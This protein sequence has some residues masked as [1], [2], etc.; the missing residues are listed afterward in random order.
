MYVLTYVTLHT[1]FLESISELREPLAIPPEDATPTSSMTTP[2]H[3]GD[4]YAFGQLIL[5][6][7]DQF[8]SS[9]SYLFSESVYSGSV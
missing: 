1:Q 2:P 6:I 9:G 3:A 7:Y 4:V 5:T 8:D